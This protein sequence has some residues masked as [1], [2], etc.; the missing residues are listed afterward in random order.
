[1]MFKL[2]LALYGVMS[3]LALI[4]FFIDK[5]AAEARDRRIPE[6]QLHLVEWL[7]GWPGAL[8]AAQLFRHKR[9]KL[10]YMIWLYLAAGVHGVTWLYVINREWL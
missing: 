2:C 9:Q 10:S 6:R 1:M 5:R 4:L 8:V 7:G 3:V